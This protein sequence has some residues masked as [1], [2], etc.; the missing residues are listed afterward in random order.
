MPIGQF[1]Q[2]RGVPGYKG[3]SR[4]PTVFCVRQTASP[5][6]LKSSDGSHT[7]VNRG[8][9]N[10]PQPLWCHNVAPSPES[11]AALVSHPVEQPSLQIRIRGAEHR[12]AIEEV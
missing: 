10:R 2:L 5:D 8:L 11:H 9:F 12:L 6:P 1:V 4:M 3:G 7:P